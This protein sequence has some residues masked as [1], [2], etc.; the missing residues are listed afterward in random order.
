[1]NIL[2]TILSILF[3]GIF[4]IIQLQKQRREKLALDLMLIYEEM[5][6]FFLKNE[7]PLKNDYIELLK[8]HKNLVV[9]PDFLDI[10]TLLLTKIAAEKK[11]H[12]KNEINWFRKTLEALPS[13]FIDI[14]Y[15]F[16]NKADKI[17][18]LSCF[19]PDFLFFTFKIIMVNFFKG[20]VTNILQRVREER[21]FI[22]H[23]ESS[24]VNA[25]IKMAV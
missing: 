13:E 20:K 25:G 10:Q 21:E 8:T 4:I 5:E 9:N 3:V 16:N 15:R 24:I 22:L 2:L 1:M 18:Q 17:I 11:G 23:N 7:I 19:K 6:M 12:L 14:H